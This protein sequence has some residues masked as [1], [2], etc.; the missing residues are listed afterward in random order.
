MH[1]ILSIYTYITTR[2]YM[3]IQVKF[4]FHISCYQLL[5][6]KELKIYTHIT[7]SIPLKKYRSCITKLSQAGLSMIFQSPPDRPAIQ[8]AIRNSIL[9][10]T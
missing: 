2:V 6:S 5:S 1:T 10:T 9:D 7:F 4:F 8:P 3:T